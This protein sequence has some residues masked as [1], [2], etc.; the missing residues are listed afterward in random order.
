M[1]I[2]TY[3]LIALSVFLQSFSFLSIKLSTMNEE[4]IMIMLIALA[5][6]F[7]IMRAFIWQILL[8]SVELSKVYPY[9]SLV[10]ILILMYAVLF[11]NERLTV[12]N[13][14]GLFIMLL[15]VYCITGKRI[16]LWK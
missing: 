6:I 8:K 5:F 1:S 2:K 10:Q 4:Y 3:F 16:F 9:T 15:G 14:I 12:Y 7:I 13:V 11:F